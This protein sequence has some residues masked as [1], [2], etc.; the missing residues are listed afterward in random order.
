MITALDLGPVERP[1]RL[2]A[3]R[4]RH[5]EVASHLSLCL[6][7]QRNQPVTLVV[8][9]RVPPLSVDM[10]RAGGWLRDDGDESPITEEV[11]GNSSP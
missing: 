6:P 5:L 11:Y 9:G 2:K 3:R 8:E 7:D 10:R 1:H 4:L